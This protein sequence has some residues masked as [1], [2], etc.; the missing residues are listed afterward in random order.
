M[1]VRQLWTVYREYLVKQKRAKNTLDRYDVAA[2]LFSEEFGSR[3]LC[4]VT[5]ST[6]E[7]Y[8]EL[9]AHRKGPSSGITARTVLSGMFRFAVRKDALAVN[10]AREA[11]MA[12][13]VAPKGRTGGAR[14]IT[15][16]E[17]RFILTAVRTSQLPCP[18]L[19]SKK[20]R[21][22]AN[23][24][25]R[26]QP[27][28]VAAFCETADL[29]DWVALLAATGLRRSQLLGLLWTDIDLDAGTL[30]TTGK[31]I[32]VTGEGLVRVEEDNDPK[33]RKGRIALPDFAIEV[34]KLRKE[35]LAERRKTK[36]PDPKVEVPDLVFPSQ[37]WTLRDPNNVQ[38]EWQRVREALGIPDD[39][40]AH[41]FRKAIATILDDAGL[42]ARIT[43][44]QLGHAD[45]S[46]AH[47][48]YMARGRAHTEAAEAINHAVTG[49]RT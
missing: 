33:N 38:H 15:V 18:R 26:Y 4:E 42:S 2:E 8:L 12:K 21:E 10:P 3:R 48:H 22:R 1:T 27:P 9:V 35:A 40:T 43:A 29:A 13:N 34:L 45:I 20:E 47:R 6:V 31:V 17:L 7:D 36:P 46:M 25:K 37:N 28:T 49:S 30:E 24:L 44:D 11:E 41:S 39:I 14:Q 5:T 19:L 16:D 32:R 23:P